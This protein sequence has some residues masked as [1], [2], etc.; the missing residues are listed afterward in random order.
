MQHALA[1]VRALVH[2]EAIPAVRQA[3]LL[4]HVAR[5][6]Q[7][8]AER[9]G[10]VRRRVVDAGDVHLGDDEH[11]H[12]RDRTDVAKR[13]HLGVLEDDLRGDLARTML[14]KRQPDMGSEPS[15]IGGA[16][17]QEKLQASSCAAAPP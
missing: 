16:R 9:R 1:R 3:Q 17:R 6:E 10:V 4:G 15:A 12:G 13:Q 5:A 11:V 7:Y 14:Q 8:L 2:D